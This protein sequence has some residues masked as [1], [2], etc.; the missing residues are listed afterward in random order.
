MQKCKVVWC[1][2]ISATLSTVFKVFRVGL[3]AFHSIID[4]VRRSTSSQTTLEET[5]SK[6]FQKSRIFAKAVKHLGARYV[7]HQISSMLLHLHRLWFR[8][9][10]AHG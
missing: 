6:V 3:R 5:D 7:V 8:H 1:R 9:L 2:L 10:H 4:A